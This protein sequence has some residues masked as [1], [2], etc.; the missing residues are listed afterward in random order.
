MKILGANLSRWTELIRRS[1]LGVHI[2]KIIPLRSNPEVARVYAGPVI[3]SV[4][5]AKIIWNYSAV[6][7]VRKTMSV[8]PGASTSRSN[9]NGSIPIASERSLP[10]P[11]SIRFQ[12][13]S[14]KA[15]LNCFAHRF[16]NGLLLLRRQA[17]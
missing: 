8:F 4:A 3:A 7:L 15:F 11:A 9:A 12:N 6:K 10:C 1:A 5:H 2:T 13:L 16:D 17:V 14:P